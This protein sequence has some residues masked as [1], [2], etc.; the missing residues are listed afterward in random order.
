MKAAV[1]AFFVS[2][3]CD[4]CDQHGEVNV[5]PDMDS[6]QIYEAAEDAHRKVSLSCSKIWKRC[7]RVSQ[8]LRRVPE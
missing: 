1:E 3:S 7:L 5:T 4:R 6:R 8:E 2:W